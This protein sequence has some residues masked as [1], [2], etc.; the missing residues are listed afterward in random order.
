MPVDVT[1]RNQLFTLLGLVL[2]VIIAFSS[3]TFASN[4]LAGFT[5]RATRRLRPGSFISH[6]DDLGRITEIGL[7]QTEIQTRHRNFNYLPNISLLTEKVMIINPEATIVS[8][9]VSLGYDV[10]HGIV[11][12]TSSAQP[13][14]VVW[15][16][17]MSA[18]GR[19]V[20]FR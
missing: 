13:K 18:S 10:H 2:T 1:V 3:T 15:K 12:N 19:W 7:I 6:G 9:E 14:G 17:P 4:I 20:T 16:I 11:E 8:A 5:L